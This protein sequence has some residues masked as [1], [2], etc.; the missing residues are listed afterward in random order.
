MNPKLLV[1]FDTNV[2]VSTVMVPNGVPQRALLKA[3][4]DGHIAQSLATLDELRLVL[5]RPKFDKYLS[6]DDRTRF[7][8]SLVRESVL[9]IIHETVTACRDPKDD[10]F[11]ELAVNASADIIVTGDEDLL[12]LHPFRGISILRPA[13]FLHQE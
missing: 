8:S 11:L 4:Q 1:V 3:I 10:K 9:V 6:R 7:L 12:V 5:E 13:D 2:L